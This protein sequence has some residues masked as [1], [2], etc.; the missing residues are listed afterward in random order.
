MIKYRD[1]AAIVL[2]V[3]NEKRKIIIK[4][5]RYSIESA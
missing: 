3:N 5:F 2:N 4:T 1:Y